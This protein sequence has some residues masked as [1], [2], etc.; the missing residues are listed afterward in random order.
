MP[1]FELIG[2]DE[3]NAISNIFKNNGGVLFDH[4]FH[5]KRNGNYEVRKLETMVKE[6]FGV[7]Y[8]LA[9]SSG[10]ASLKVVLACSN[11]RKNSEILIQAHNFIAD[12]EVI[13][14]FGAKPVV[15]NIDKTLNMDID[16]LKQ[17]I[18][19]NTTAVIISDMLGNGNDIASIEKICK[20]NNLFLIDDACEIM[21]G[22]Y[23]DKYYGTFGDAGVFSLDFG[24]NITCGEGG[25][26]L[27]NNEELYEKMK[28]YIDH[29]H[30]NNENYQRG[31]DDFGIP[32]FNFRMTEMQGSI[33]IVQLKKLDYIIKNNELRYTILKNKLSHI[34]HRKIHLNVKLSYDTFIFFESNFIV[35]K[36]IIDHLKSIGFGTKNLPDAMRWHC[37]YYWD[38]LIDSNQKDK[39]KFTK[40]MLSDSI[41]IPILLQK[42]EQFYSDISD[43]IISIYDKFDRTDYA[44]EFEYM[45][46]IPARSGSKGLPNKNCIKLKNGKTLIELVTRKADD[47]KLIE[48]VFFS[49]DSQK[50]KDIYLRE[51]ITKDITCD[52]IRNPKI[53]TDTSQPSEYIIDAI[54]FLKSKNITVKNI[55]LLQ[56]TSPLYNTNDIDNAILQHKK[57]KR[58]KL[59]SV[60]VPLQHPQDMIKLN[61]EGIY[62][63]FVP[64]N[65]QLYDKYAYINGCIYISDTN[66]FY[67]DKS[68]FTKDDTTIYMM[69]TLS[70]I[71]IDT[72]DDLSIL[73]GIL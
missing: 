30:C 38:H 40:K 36:L 56:V 63:S 73:N 13:H 24:K 26:I 28:Q 11:I 62:D 68:F 2:D 41:A 31:M 53:S 1:G 50:Y 47:S 43:N 7:K 37:A 21:G 17:S 6:Y 23:G 72:S 18:T 25:L 48:C 42:D 61:D 16:D 70:G 19:P 20:D 27:T 71:D 8:C 59:V 3:L 66:A 5:S 67:K 69:N 22:K 44:I 9:T 12:A 65:R 29:G 4:G 60:S 64:K 14:D 35:R 45:A 51:S 55:V 49:T 39:L 57:S 34:E 46:L 58:N 32:G 54:E 10:T 33:A 52:Y 15:I